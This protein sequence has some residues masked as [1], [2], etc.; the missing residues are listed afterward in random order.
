[1]RGVRHTFLVDASCDFSRG[2]VGIGVVMRATEKPGSR[3]GP[4]VDTYSEAYARVPPGAAEKFAILRA[5]EI[6]SEHSA[7][8]V[9]IRSDYNYMRRTLKRDHASD[10]GGEREDLHGT[11]LRLARDF[12]EVKFAYVP[13]RK[14]QEAHRLARDAT[15]LTEV[16]DRTDILWGDAS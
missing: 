10:V 11:I 14:N 12:E 13:R 1:M 3:P 8:R 9:K 7:R 5:L 15:R 16:S 2:I 4:I 6:A